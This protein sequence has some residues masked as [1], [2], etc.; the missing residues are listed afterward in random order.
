MTA[1]S[2]KYGNGKVL[3]S[4]DNPSTIITYVVAQVSKAAGQLQFYQQRGSVLVIVRSFRNEI[5]F[6]RA[7]YTERL[8]T[9]VPHNTVVQ[10]CNASGEYAAR[11]S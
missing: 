9:Q 3:I 10:T 7:M 4:P 8:I 1:C 11:I 2:A 6:A 5:A